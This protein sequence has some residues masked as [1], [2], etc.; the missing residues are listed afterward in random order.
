MFRIKQRTHEVPLITVVIM[1]FFVSW[2]ALTGCTKGQHSYHERSAT[3]HEHS[4]HGGESETLAKDDT[5]ETHHGHAHDHDHGHGHQHGESNVKHVDPSI[6]QNFVPLQNLTFYKAF[7]FDPNKN[8][9]VKVTYT[10][11]E[12][13]IVSIK[14]LRRE[15]RELF[16]A[17]IVNNE[18]R[19]AGEH[20]EHWDG[21][22]YWGEYLDHKKQPYRFIYKAIKPAKS[23]SEFQGLEYAEGQ[24]QAE[25]AAKAGFEGIHDHSRHDQ[26]Y[27]STPFLTIISPKVDEV[28]KGIIQVE[29]SVSAE[30]RGYGDKYG[31]GVRYYIDMTLVSEEFYTPE[32]NGKFVYALDTTPFENGKHILYVGMCDHNEHTTSRGIDITLN[33]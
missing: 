24:S 29:S 18:R 28:V 20:V 11:S 9:K 22:D 16:L 3:P 32:S 14:A 25:S 7:T 27:E 17:G 31:Y 4:Q 26:H 19:E 13:A 1:F 21:K 23:K 15:T 6:V 8:E 5:E 2:V 30:K 10:L 33:N 12:P